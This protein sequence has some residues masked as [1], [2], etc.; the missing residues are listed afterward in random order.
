[1]MIHDK[2]IPFSALGN[3]NNVGYCLTLITIN[4]MKRPF[5]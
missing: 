1:M 3:G 2:I 5:K 4:Y